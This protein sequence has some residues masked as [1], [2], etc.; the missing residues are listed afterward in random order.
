MLTA[1]AFTP[2][3]MFN[4]ISMSRARKNGS[5]IIT[6]DDVNDSSHEITRP[7]HKNTGKT[8]LVCVVTPIGLDKAVHTIHYNQVA[9]PH[10]MEIRHERL[11]QMSKSNTN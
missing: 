5:K 7:I 11:C 10:N 1:V 4:M 8:S 6:K 3:M 2:E 9:G